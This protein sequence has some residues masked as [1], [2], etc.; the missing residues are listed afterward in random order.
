MTD[1]S[2]DGRLLRGDRA[3]GR[4]LRHAVDIASLEGLEALSLGRIAADLHVSKSGV[5]SLFGSKEE[6][7]LATIRAAGQIYLQKVVEPAMAL[8]AGCGR[9]WQLCDAYVDYLAAKVFP[10]GC[11]FFSVQAEFDSRPGRVRDLLRDISRRWFEIVRQTV[12]EAQAAGELS[13]SVAADQ[14]AFELIAFLEAANGYSLLHD[15][16][17]AYSMA[18]EAVSSR[19]RAVATDPAMVPHR[20]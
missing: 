6:L 5:F 9:L 10:G 2:Q 12:I 11:F 19:L 16:Q 14:L 15:D 13:A 1:S 4:I 3:R 17:R 8:P 7:Q 20:A 18:R